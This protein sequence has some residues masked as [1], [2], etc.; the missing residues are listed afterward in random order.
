MPFAPPIVGGS[1]IIDDG[2]GHGGETP[3]DTFTIDNNDNRS[4]IPGPG[5]TGYR[6]GGGGGSGI[7][8]AFYYGPKMIPPINPTLLTLPGINSFLQLPR[9]GN[10]QIGGGDKRVGGGSKYENFSPAKG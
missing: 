6:T 10:K 8:D 5:P 4:G 3:S 7:Y 2:L 9:F 1:G